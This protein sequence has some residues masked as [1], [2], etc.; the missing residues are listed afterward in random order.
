MTIKDLKTGSYKLD[1]V[2]DTNSDVLSL[3]FTSGLELRT[4]LDMPTSMRHML[5]L[6]LLQWNIQNLGPDQLRDI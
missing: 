5:Q 4:P 1:F 6:Y 2:P 3:P